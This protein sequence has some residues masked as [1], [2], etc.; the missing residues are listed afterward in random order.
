MHAV[1]W[2]C[3]IVTEWVL[4]NPSFSSLLC[5]DLPGELLMNKP[6]SVSHV[7]TLANVCRPQKKATAQDSH[8]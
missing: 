3:V 1:E 2:Q 6:A 8:P 5:L 7:G 4:E